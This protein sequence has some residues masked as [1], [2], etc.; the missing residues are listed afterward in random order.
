MV[1]QKCSKQGKLGYEGDRCLVDVEFL[2]GGK[3]AIEIN[4]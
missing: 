2:D 4:A 3:Q 1:S